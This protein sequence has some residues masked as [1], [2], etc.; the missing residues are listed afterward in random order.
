MN[1]TIHIII[2]IYHGNVVLQIFSNI[3]ILRLRLYFTL[4]MISDMGRGITMSDAFAPLMAA[5]K[6]VFSK[7]FEHNVATVLAGVSIDQ[8][9]F[10]LAYFD[11]FTINSVHYH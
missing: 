2:V 1:Y 4:R 11:L 6:S 3:S 8:K 5:N 7:D 9:R 10:C